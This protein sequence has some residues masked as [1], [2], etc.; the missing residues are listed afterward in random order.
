MRVEFG[1]RV[2]QL[3]FATHAVVT[4]IGPMGF[5]FAGE[6]ALGRRMARHLKRHRLS[7]FFSQQGFPLVVGFL[8]FEGHTLKVN[9]EE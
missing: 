2:K 7:P 4:A 3:G 8:S 6:G 1:A 9:L 5:V